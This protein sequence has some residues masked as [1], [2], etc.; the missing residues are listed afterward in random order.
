MAKEYRRDVVEAI[1]KR[2]CLTD[3]EISN[4]TPKEALRHYLEWEGI[5][6]YTSAIVSIFE[7]KDKGSDLR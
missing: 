5:L 6:G 4:L 3:D 7:S 2:T 1:K